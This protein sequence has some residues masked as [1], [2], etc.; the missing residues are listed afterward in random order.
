MNEK[1]SCVLCFCHLADLN[2]LD[3]LRPYDRRISKGA[4]PARRREFLLSLDSFLGPLNSV[5]DRTEMV[6]AWLSTHH[7]D[8]S[9]ARNPIIKP[10][11][12]SPPR[13][14]YSQYLFNLVPMSLSSALTTTSGTHVF[15]YLPYLTL[16]LLLSNTSL[17]ES[18]CFPIF[19]P[20]PK[21]TPPYLRHSVCFIFGL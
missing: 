4:G 17:N 12:S 3:V 9:P 16:R 2:A 7:T 1:V 19:L 14:G 18:C 13:L 21:L 8:G 5:S 11:L 15:P 6:F 20:G 10:W